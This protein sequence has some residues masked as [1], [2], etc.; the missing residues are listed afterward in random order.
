MASFE[1]TIWGDGLMASGWQNKVGTHALSRRSHL[2]DLLDTLDT[3]GLVMIKREAE[4]ASNPSGKLRHVA[5]PLATCQIDDLLQ[6]QQHLY[7]S[8]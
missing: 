3:H 1:C 7:S 8:I 5:V 2:S 6:D 4:Q